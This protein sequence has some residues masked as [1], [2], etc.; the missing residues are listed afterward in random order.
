MTVIILV[1]VFSLPFCL[2]LPDGDYPV[3]LDGDT[4]TLN[5]TKVVPKIFDERLPYR[6]FFKGELDKISK[7]GVLFRKGNNK[8]IDVNDLT[9]IKEFG[10]IIK[11]FTKEGKEIVPQI[12]HNDVNLQ[13]SDIIRDVF[14]KMEEKHG[15]V[16][17]DW[18]STQE[19]YLGRQIII[20]GEI[21]RDRQ[22]RFRYTKIKYSS[23]KKL[24][25]KEEFVRAIKAVN[26]LIDLYREYTHAYWITNITEDE[27]FI[28]KNVSETQLSQ[29]YSYKG[30]IQTKP[31]CSFDIVNDIKNQLIAQ[32]PRFPY[33]M[34][35]LD[36]KKSFNEKN[37]YLSVVYAI[38]ALESI[39]KMCILIHTG[40]RN[41]SKTQ[42]KKFMDA[43]LNF[44]V[45]IAL[46]NFV[47]SAD[48]TDD[49]IDK[50][51]L[52]IKIRNDIIHKTKLDVTE[53]HAIDTLE[54]IQK[55]A[56]VL[57]KDLSQYTSQP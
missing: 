30:F 41:F 44:L 9:N 6:G 24:H 14:T 23:P 25:Y 18:S 45:T 32:E 38:T 47:L 21:K 19:F 22:G 54:N 1:L 13:E 46:K 55:M 39:V 4:V 29:A 34:L 8:E 53:K 7:L 11:Y 17:D 15:D 27:I 20:N 33:F 48:F 16:P 57:I 42:E 12:I 28:Y 51:V 35:I 50:V 10:T 3:K 5:L 37:Y 52:G 56:D 36:A 40:K 2:L 43:S 26:I 31:D 49:L